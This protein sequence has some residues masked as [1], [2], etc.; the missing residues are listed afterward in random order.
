VNT[1]SSTNKKRIRIHEPKVNRFR[2]YISLGI[3]FIWLVIGY[4]A[5]KDVSSFVEWFEKLGPTAPI[6]FT[7]MLSLAVVLLV[8][9]PIL[10]VGA[11]AIFPYWIAVVVNFTASI[12]GGLM[13]F[14]LG[15]WMF[16]EKIESLVSG[17]VR[18]KR[19]ESAISEEAMQISVLVRLSPIIPD[20]WLNYVMSTSPV[21]TRVFFISNLSSIVYCLAYAY[22][23]HAAGK[24]VLSGEGMDGFKDSPGGYALLF[25]GVIASILATILVTKVTMKALQSKVDVN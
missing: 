14:F 10:K 18:L 19:L 11:G 16:R 13:A 5:F 8:P 7:I 1:L 6:L 9:T 15:R 17:D 4:F 12:I 23:G 21:T 3:V 25:I 22:F 2:I 24:I 20:E